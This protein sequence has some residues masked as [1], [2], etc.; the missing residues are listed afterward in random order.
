MAGATDAAD[1]ARATEATAATAATETTTEA[2]DWRRLDSTVVLATPWF[3]VRQDAVIRP[4]GA[5]DVYHHVATPGSVTVLPVAD[6]GRVLL[7]R[8]WI[9]THGGVQWRLPAGTIEPF[10]ERPLAAARR[11]LAEETGLRAARWGALGAVN[12]AD[13]LTNHVDHVFVA[14]DLTQ[15]EAAREGGEADMALCWLS[16][17]QALELVWSGQ[18]RHAGS[19]YALLS[20]GHLREPLA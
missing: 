10:D 9:Y 7:T 8:Q 11:E 18:I 5:A 2:T 15:G 4:D 17:E 16:F 3:D 13:S 1:G 19:A 20:F 14:Q 12:G 6:D